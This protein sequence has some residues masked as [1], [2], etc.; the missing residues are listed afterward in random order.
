MAMLCDAVSRK[1]LDALRALDKL[2]TVDFDFTARKRARATGWQ[3]SDRAP[4]Y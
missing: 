2:T 1:L 4:S 3:S